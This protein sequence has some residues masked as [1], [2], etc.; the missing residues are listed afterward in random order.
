MKA[1]GQGAPCRLSD[2]RLLPT[3]GL[4][5][6]NGWFPGAAT[7]VGMG[8][9]WEFL[10]QSSLLPRGLGPDWECVVWDRPWLLDR[11]G[12]GTAPRGH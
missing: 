9:S 6:S 3:A 4:R 1:P 7:L 10:V 5:G 2:H 8:Y 12:H 11:G